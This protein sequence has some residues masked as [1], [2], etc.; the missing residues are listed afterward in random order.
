[1]FDIIVYLA[2]ICRRYL[3]YRAT[4]ITLIYEFFVVHG[5]VAVK[6]YKDIAHVLELL[7]IEDVPY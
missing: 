1:M 2:Y 3:K 7:I 6:M 4:R 5:K